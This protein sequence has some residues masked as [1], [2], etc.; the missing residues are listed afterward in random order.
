MELIAENSTYLLN[1][2]GHACA[3]ADSR[4]TNIQAYDFVYISNK[5]GILS[6]SGSNGSQTFTRENQS[7]YI[8]AKG[9][10]ELCVEASK[11]FQIVRALPKNQPVKL[12]SLKDK[13]RAVINSGRSK[14]QLKIIEPTTYPQLEVLKNQTGSFKVAAK[15]FV[16]LVNDAAY[17]AGRTD[18][19]AYLNSVYLKAKNNTLYGVGTDG[20]RLSAIKHSI[21]G[22]GN[23]DLDL[24][25]PINA[26]LVFARL[27]E[28]AEFLE[29]SF[30]GS[31]AQFNWGGLIYS[32]TLVDGKYPDVMKLL[33]TRC[34]SKLVAN[35]ENLAD[36]LKRM[37]VL[38]SDDK[39]PKVQ[40]S[41]CDNLIKFKALSNSDEDLG[42]DEV[43]GASA[44]NAI[45]FVYGLNPR[46]L[47]DALNHI[48][49]ENVELLFTDQLSA[50]CVGA[51]DCK[52]TRALIMPVRI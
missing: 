32:T 1:F 11:F 37:L 2:I 20:H 26:A 45:D 8:Q 46:Y 36:S 17:A 28:S 22:D 23:A 38:V 9:D 6:I 31:R 5:Q 19:R 3:N 12:K 4:K 15:T 33:P 51:T 42:L 25:I 47:L 16:Q 43:A 14:L 48:Q 39:H 49:G 10:G 24:V 44:G 13:D 30:N 21:E 34:D 18:A 35:K 50:F 41:F 52:N 29:V 27:N 40:M 7:E